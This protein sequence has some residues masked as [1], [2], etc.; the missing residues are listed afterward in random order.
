MTPADTAP[1]TAAIILAAG[2]GTR[3][4]SSLSKVL[5]PVGGRAMIG[6]VVSAAEKLNPQRIAAVIG[7]HAPEVGDYVKAMVPSASIAVQEPPQGTAHAVLKAI[8][9]IES[10]EGAVLVLYADTPLVTPETLR[11]LADAIAHG[12]SV[13]VLGFTPPDPGAYGRLVRDKSGN[14]AAIVEAKDASAEE[15]KITLCN[16]GVMAV[17]A[18]FLRSEL[19]NI[20]NDN[21][22]G[23]Y[24]LTDIVALAREHNKDCAVIEAD[25]QE[26]LGVNSRVELAEA[27]AIFQ[28][29]MRQS[30]MEN[31]ATLIDPDTVYFSFDTQIGKDVVIGPN[32]IFG[33][34]VRIDDRVEIKPFS[35][36]EGAQISAG[37]MVGPY[38][39]LRPGAMIGKEAKV[40]NFVEIKK[41]MVA[42]GAKISH[43]TYIGDADIGPRAN[44]GAG[45]I[46]CNY[47]GYNKHKTTIGADAFIGSNTSLVAPV[48]INDGAYVGSGSV[49]TKN[50]ESGDLA[51]ARGRQSAIKGWAARF[52]KSCEK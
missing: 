29:R 34:G 45:T 41:S 19:K 2:H 42:Q 16:S 43:L 1:P 14:L 23:E 10:F 52:K 33:P 28:T 11:A 35:H 30:T 37:A 47:D 24:Y 49:I 4:R 22:K 3:M 9:A 46:T 18:A 38:A 48:T 31:G 50:V 51:V 7:N 5:H 25:P 36:L 32:V 39:R 17:D 20:G 15:L 44:I 13:A 12:A 8:P 26:V 6:H 40:G 21:A 27:E